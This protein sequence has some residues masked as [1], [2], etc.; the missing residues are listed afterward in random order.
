MK[1]LKFPFREYPVLDNKG[2]IISL[3]YRPVIDLR[4]IS[5]NKSRLFPALIDSGADESL[6]PGWM[7]KFLGHHLEKGRKVRI[8][9]GVGGEIKAY[10]HQT[11][12]ELKGIGFRCDIYYSDKFNDWEYGLLGERSFFSRFK[13]ELDYKDKL[14]TLIQK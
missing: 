3:A 4:L 5:G 11:Y 14:I 8:F 9:R 12:L 6:F 7:A 10:L 1:V 13:V 2:K